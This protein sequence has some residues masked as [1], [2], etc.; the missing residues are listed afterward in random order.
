MSTQRYYSPNASFV[1]RFFSLPAPFLVK[2]SWQA[3]LNLAHAQTT[4]TVFNLTPFIACTKTDIRE[5][6]AGVRKRKSGKKTKDLLTFVPLEFL[7]LC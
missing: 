7:L 5:K 3:L 1:C 6:A 4:L 2:L